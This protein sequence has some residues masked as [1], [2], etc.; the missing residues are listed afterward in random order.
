MKHTT[1]IALAVLVMAATGCET[2]PKKTTTEAA[3]TELP[4]PFV[5]KFQ[6]GLDMMG[7]APPAVVFNDAPTQQPAVIVPSGVYPLTTVN[8]TT[9]GGT[10]IVNYGFPEYR[11]RVPSYPY[12]DY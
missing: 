3:P 6:P 11:P 10:R 7:I 2:A 8:P 5:P 12:F 1:T 9:S 4:K